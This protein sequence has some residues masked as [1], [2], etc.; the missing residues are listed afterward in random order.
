MLTVVVTVPVAAFGQL[1]LTWC[2]GTAGA[3]TTGRCIAVTYADLVGRADVAPDLDAAVRKWVQALSPASA[4]DA[5]YASAERERIFRDA[6]TKF[7]AF[8]NGDSLAP[9]TQ[10]GQG[11]EYAFAILA[12]VEQNFHRMFVNVLNGT[13]SPR[14]GDLADSSAAWRQRRDQATRLLIAAAGAV[15]QA[16]ARQ[17]TP[18]GVYDR[19]SLTK[20]ERDS[21]AR[22]IVSRFPGLKP[23]GPVATDLRYGPQMLLSTLTDPKWKSTPTSK[24]GR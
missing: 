13:D 1:P 15:Q 7:A 12:N 17:S 11:G 3:D 8:A 14:P 23:T 10:A 16:L 21:L 5:V 2:A 19:L 6:A 9:D 22:F 4:A 20:P 18:G 24:I